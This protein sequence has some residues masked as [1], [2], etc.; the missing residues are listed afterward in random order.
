MKAK[1]ESSR[2]PDGPD[3]GVTPRYITKKSPRNVGMA[4][5][6]TS[7]TNISCFQWDLFLDHTGC[8]PLRRRDRAVVCLRA[9]EAGERSRRYS[10]YGLGKPFRAR[11]RSIRHKASHSLRRAAAFCRGRDAGYP[12]PPHR[13]VRAGLL[14]TAPVLLRKPC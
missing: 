7:L 2:G 4:P 10:S 8:D 13:S 3:Q 1:D 12:T 5:F 11:L 6:K 14:H 9:A